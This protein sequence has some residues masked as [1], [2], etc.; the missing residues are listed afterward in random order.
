[1]R[2]F[3]KIFNEKIMFIKIQEK[4]TF[5]NII[6][7]IW[8]LKAMPMLQKLLLGV[9]ATWPAQRVPCRLESE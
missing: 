3:K 8:A 2:A 6:P 1:M 7:P 9:A 5:E 4:T